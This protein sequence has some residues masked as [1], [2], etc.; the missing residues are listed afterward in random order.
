MKQNSVFQVLIPKFQQDYRNGSP[1]R[2]CGTPSV[3]SPSST[4]LPTPSQTSGESSGNP[5]SNPS[6]TPSCELLNPDDHTDIG[7]N[8]LRR[9]ERMTQDSLFEPPS[10]LCRTSADNNQPAR[11]EQDRNAKLEKMRTLEQQ[12]MYDKAKTEWDRMMHEHEAIKMTRSHMPPLLPPCSSQ[13]SV[14]VPYPCTFANQNGI[15]MQGA[16]RRSIYP[17]PLQPT[18]PPSSVSN[19]SINTPMMVS[20]P[21]V[22]GPNMPMSQPLRPSLNPSAC[23]MQYSQ[24]SFMCCAYPSSTYPPSQGY[25]HINGAASSY[26]PSSF[27]PNNGNVT[28]QPRDYGMYQ[29]GIRAVCSPE[30]MENEMWNRQ[31]PAV[32]ADFN[33]TFPNQK[34]QYHPNGAVVDE[35]LLDAVASTNAMFA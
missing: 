3:C 34:V 32:S 18:E 15:V 8:P 16:C 31:I 33:N 10:K 25:S 9:M 29:Q 19:I 1:M 7:D 24:C 2:S 35:K 27:A 5:P 23:N 17:Q 26:F 20:L 28:P 13:S 6:E 14:P 30:K 21:Q 12:I 11:R 4:M 22:S